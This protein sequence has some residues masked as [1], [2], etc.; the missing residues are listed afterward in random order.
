MGH[1]LTLVRHDV[2]LW[3]R[4]V[5]ALAVSD[6]AA[7]RRSREELL[8]GDFERILPG[9]GD[10][11]ERGGP[12]A[13]RAT[14]LEGALARPGRGSRR[15][16]SAAKEPR[17]HRIA[18]TSELGA[19]AD[20]VW[21]HATS[22]A[23]I[24]RELAPLLCMTFPR[25]LDDLAAAWQPGRRRFRSWLLLGGVLP[26]EYDDLVLAEVEPGRRFLERSSLLTQRVWEHERVIEPLAGG[27]RLTDRVA[28][29]P[30]VPWLGAVAER[31]VRALFRLRH[32]NLRRR[33]GTPAAPGP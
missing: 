24:N 14:G 33:F 17:L 29:E 8:T 2:D 21:R 3:S 12:A 5:R 16:G 31:V 18:I 19:P 32:R 4:L 15:D 28:F 27:C 22:P 9:H 6:R 25:E 20:A 23:G 7:L 10:V 13:L 30:R 11:L 1:P 26:V